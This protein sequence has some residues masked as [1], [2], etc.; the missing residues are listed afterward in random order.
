MI[1]QNKFVTYLSYALG[2]IL[3][4]VA[5]ILIAF[6]IDKITREAT[7]NQEELESYELIISDLKRDSVLFIKYEQLYNNYLDSYFD[8]NKI[9][10]N[11]GSFE[12][13]F[14]DFLV[15]NAQFNPVTHNNH[16]ATIEKLRNNL[17]RE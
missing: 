9:K 11:E 10:P 2:E 6:Q 8:L 14:P 15:M 7:L 17:I 12:T 16:Q 5:G 13:V 3:L 4:L 1:S